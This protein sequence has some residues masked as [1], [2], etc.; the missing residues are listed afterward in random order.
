[1]LIITILQPSIATLQY[2][3]KPEYSPRHLLTAS[4]STHQWP[5]VV[6]SLELFLISL[7]LH[8]HG[9]NTVYLM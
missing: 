9:C 1:M 5:L 4:Q 8:T 7:E 6:V 2:Y 3:N